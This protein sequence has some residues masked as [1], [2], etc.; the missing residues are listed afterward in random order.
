MHKIVFMYPDGC[1]REMR[2]WWQHMNS[3]TITAVY[4]FAY[5]SLGWLGWSRG[6]VFEGALPLHARCQ[7]PHQHSSSD[8]PQIA[9]QGHWSSCFSTHQ[10]I[11]ETSSEAWLQVIAFS[12]NIARLVAV[13]KHKLNSHYTLM[14]LSWHWFSNDIIHISIE[15]CQQSCHIPIITCTGIEKPHPPCRSGLLCYLPILDLQHHR[16]LDSSL[17]SKSAIRI[18]L[19]INE[20]TKGN[21]APSTA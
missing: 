14:S 21:V 10:V 2:P 6:S 5:G 17:L 13:T 19:A 18:H 12:R 16:I 7:Y 3:S 11:V 4:G 15:T 1:P 8:S 9:F 20:V